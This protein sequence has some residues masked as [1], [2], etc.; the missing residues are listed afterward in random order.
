MS[1]EDKAVP[2]TVVAPPSSQQQSSSPPRRHVKTATAAR[3]RK[4]QEDDN[5]NTVRSSSTTKTASTSLPEVDV[6]AILPDVDPFLGVSVHHLSTTFLIRVR[7]AKLDRNARIYEIE[8]LQAP[9][10]GVIRTASARVRS[11]V[12][13]K[14]G[15]SYVHSLLAMHHKY[16]GDVGTATFMLSYSWGYTIGD[17]IDTLQ[18]H[19][20]RQSLNPKTTYIWICCMCVNQHRV[21]EQAL[22][23]ATMKKS[24]NTSSGILLPSSSSSPSTSSV[25]FFDEFRN[26][27]VG[28]GHILAMMTP[29]DDP[30]YL[31]RVWCIFEVFTANEQDNNCQVTIVMPP[32]QE[33]KLEEAILSSSDDNTNKSGVVDPLFEA[34]A[35]TRVEK[36]HASVEDDR[37]QILG[38]VEQGVGFRNLN[39]RVNDFLR[40]WVRGVIDSIVQARSKEIQDDEDDGAVVV[41]NNLSQLKFYDDIGRLLLRNHETDAALK[42][43]KDGLKKKK[44]LFSSAS[45]NSSNK[46]NNSKMHPSIATSYNNIGHVYDETG[47]HEQALNMHKKALAIY[48]FVS[49][50]DHPNTAIS[51]TAIGN[52]LEAKGDYDEAL[53]YYQKSLV[54]NE[55]FY[56]KLDSKTAIAHLNCGNVLYVKGSLGKAVSHFHQAIEIQEM[57]LGG[58]HPDMAN[59]YNSMGEIVGRL[60]NHEQAL[61][62]HYKSL[63]IK[64][65]VLG[66]NHPETAVSCCNIGGVLFSLNNLDG[67]LQQCSRALAI[68]DNAESGAFHP[69]TA[70][71]YNNIGVIRAKYGHHGEALE[72]LGKALQI[73][74]QTLGKDHP[75]TMA[76]ES[77]IQQ[78][79]T[80]QKRD[81]NLL[82][83]YKAVALLEF[84]YTLE[85]IGL[86]AAY[87]DVGCVWAEKNDHAMALVWFRKCLAIHK[88]VLGDSHEKTASCR[89][90]VGVQLYM[91]DDYDG[92][93]VEYEKALEIQE[94]IFGSNHLSTALTYS[95]IGALFHIQRDDDRSLKYHRKALAVRESLLGPYHESTKEA[96]D[97]IEVGLQ[98]KRNAEICRKLNRT[99]D[100][101]KTSAYY[102]EE[103]TGINNAIQRFVLKNKRN[104][105]TLA[106]MY[107]NIGTVYEEKGAFDEALKAF[108]TATTIQESL[109]KTSPEVAR[110]YIRMGTVLNTKGDCDK[111]IQLFN[112]ALRITDPVLGLATETAKAHNS[113]G[114]IL[115]RQGDY[116]SALT[117]YRKALAVRTSA[118]GKEH[119]DTMFSCILIASVLEL[120]GDYGGAITELRRV[121]ELK[122]SS[123]E[124]HDQSDIATHHRKIA[125]ILGQMGDVKGSLK[126]YYEADACGDQ[127]GTNESNAGGMEIEKN[128]GGALALYKKALAERATTLGEN[129]PI[130][131]IAQLNIG[132]V[133]V[134]QG[135]YSKAVQEYRN[136]AKRE[137]NGS[138]TTSQ[139]GV[140]YT[141]YIVGEVNQKIQDYD[142]ALVAYTKAAKLREKALGPNHLLLATCFLQ[143][144]LTHK[145]K[146]DF[147]SAL[148]A[149]KKCLA[150]EETVLG[151]E[152][153]DIGGTLSGIADL[154][155]KLGELD[156][157]I[158]TYRR[159]LTIRLRALGENHRT[160]AVIYYNIAGILETKK[161]YRGALDSYRKCL[162]IEESLGIDCTST[163]YRLAR[164]LKALGEY[165]EALREFQHC[166][167]V[168]EKTMGKD[169]V[170][171]ATTYIMIGEILS[172]KKDY[173]NSLAAFN[174]AVRIQEQHAGNS[175]QTYV[176]YNAILKLHMERE[177]YAA[178]LVVHHK[179]H[180]LLVERFGTEDPRV[181]TS[182]R[183]I[184]DALSEA[185]Y[186]SAG[187][188]EY[189]LALAIYES[190]PDPE[191]EKIF[192]VYDKIGRILESTCDYKE[193]IANYRMSASS[194]ERFLENRALIAYTYIAIAGLFEKLEDYDAA[195]VEYRK[196]LQIRKCVL[197]ENHTDTASIYIYIGSALTDSGNYDE[198]L[199]N[200]K[201][202]LTIE[203]TALGNHS[204][205]IDTAN[206]YRDIAYCS[207][208]KGDPGEALAA[209]L[210]CIEIQESILGENHS[211]VAAMYNKAGE[212]EEQ[213]E[214][215]DH[216]LLFYRNSLRIYTALSDTTDASTLAQVH[217]NIGDA[218]VF[219]GKHDDAL[220]EHHKALELY[221]STCGP[222]HEDTARAHFD[223]GYDY[224]CKGDYHNA[225]A[226]YRQA[227]G[228]RESVFGRNHA[229]T[230]KCWNNI[231]VVL[232]SLQDYAG[233]LQHHQT[234]WEI[235]QSVL[236]ERHRLTVKSHEKVKALLGKV[237]G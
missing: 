165:D 233:A 44:K 158:D 204:H 73:R 199:Q 56:G 28:I 25:N 78:L 112:K 10:P 86:A 49:G 95:N 192:I 81:D 39:H 92:A 144:A 26:R 163:R 134:L 152:H 208:E 171:V 122:K 146:E 200:Y 226:S 89:N 225:L 94:K 43:F 1:K 189:R 141:Y 101:T 76:T 237:K 9:S 64:E 224:K 140:A 133:L 66:T 161:D 159:S 6:D 46:N 62:Y 190:F 41:D 16:H 116:T 72:C 209:Y 172:E 51:Y 55:R 148:A 91:T 37:I 90:N 60:G 111:A 2:V 215:Y 53:E 107:S 97:N 35:K 131:I 119:A 68:F 75:D 74:E 181:A 31:K 180:A 132:R 191:Y 12:D 212:I 3:R 99:P 153:P 48:S 82:E 213:L 71:C 96:R 29:W 130:C 183:L 22:S 170:D 63:A 220:I 138:G 21:V 27:V 15:A 8:N 196:G 36:A 188:V 157:A 69:K 223:I 113:I 5:N 121:I 169:H 234:A 155:E 67:A 184:G 50:E 166:I 168:E 167:A 217:S 222:N 32:L 61:D 104:H 139:A 143:I 202:A 150:V 34:L 7:A 100:G 4:T 210:R 232:E 11:P 194:Q 77:D 127:V 84:N 70:T 93:L 162:R 145:K 40:R 120:M 149:Y 118:L 102:D 187:L 33:Q 186:N 235:R 147:G 229:S 14:W 85:G 114:K 80:N 19:C 173:P 13:G 207:K 203:E 136:V 108:R 47:D 54:I 103:I 126:E 214:N 58:N 45:N 128:Y 125:A 198:A 59:T 30:L 151:K 129:H 123:S 230:A 83:L 156:T 206:L 105:P 160:T 98:A 23:Q 164:T 110:C 109:G 24:S 115:E 87:N 175:A 142:A 195:V 193:A 17:I 178:A 221:T 236:G 231:G 197:G 124:N 218:L 177:D 117:E 42:L 216:A 179:R 106:T 227:L 228:V 182:H 135:D 176:T 57:A 38:M 185:G 88:V 211:D 52:V 219:N 137:N 79:L 65:S 201:R 154:L 205:S 20:E 18:T 174:K